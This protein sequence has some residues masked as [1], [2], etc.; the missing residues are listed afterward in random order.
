MVTIVRMIRKSNRHKLLLVLWLLLWAAFAAVLWYPVAD[1]YTRSGV[2]VLAAGLWAMPLA[3]WPRWPVRT[4]CVALAVAAAA[5]LFLP[6]REVDRQQ[7]RELYVQRLVAF[8]GTK[9]V[10]G[11]ENEAG[12]DCS[13]LIR[14]AMV[15]AELIQGLRTV[16]PGLIRQGLAIWWNDCTARELGQGHDGQTRQIATAELGAIN[17]QTLQPGDMAIINGGT[18]IIAYVDGQTWIEADP[19]RGKVMT[20]TLSDHYYKLTSA[21]GILVRWVQLSNQ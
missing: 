17:P 12:I 14:R 20:F 8:D 6:G 15:E 16:N 19:N 4:G 21:Q 10:W 7:L 11:G 9:Y 5:L 13:G 2:I 18:H 1:E 3:I